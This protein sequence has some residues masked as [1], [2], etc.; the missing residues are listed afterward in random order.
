VTGRAWDA[1]AAVRDPEMPMLTIADLGVLRDVEVD[2]GARL[3]VT[4][5]PTYLGCPALDVIRSD[6]RAA[7]RAAGYPDVEVVTSLAPAWTTDRLSDKARAVL[8]ASGIAPPARTGTETRRSLPLVDPA[9]PCP[10]CSS[11]DTEET[12]HFGPTAC[13]ALRHCRQCREPFQH[14]KEVR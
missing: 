9:T 3:R 4:I 11:A 13:T 6:I 10:R 12:A 8:S 2:D 1:V 5:T 7:A 14:M